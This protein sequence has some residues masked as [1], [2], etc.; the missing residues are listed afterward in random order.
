MSDRRR[1]VFRGSALGLFGS[2][3]PGE[4][5]VRRSCRVVIRRK[6][7]RRQPAISQKSRRPWRAWRA[8]S[9]WSAWSG[10]SQLRSSGFDSSTWS[11]IFAIPP[12]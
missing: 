9:P 8:S 2:G 1:L 3:G 6:E 12:V 11:R 7:A 10:G 5:A 4:G